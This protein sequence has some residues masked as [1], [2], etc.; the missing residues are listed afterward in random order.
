MPGA[1]AVRFSGCVCL[2][3]GVAC[4]FAG[5]VLG[6]LAIQQAT[7][8]SAYHHA[9]ACLAGAR[10]DADCLHA[11]DGSVAG[12]T[13]SPGSGRV[14]ADYALDVRT[15]STTLH[16]T[17]SSDSPML[18]DALDGDPAVLTMWRGV[19]VSVVTDGR[20]EVTTSVPDTALASDLGNSEL[21]GGVG[22]LFV[23]GAR[24]ARRNRRAGGAQPLTRP[25]LP[26]PLLPLGLCGIVVAVVGAAPARRRLRDAPDPPVSTA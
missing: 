13:E 26:P 4:L 16:L 24:A 18:A 20:S 21:T 8:I 12:V 17:F 11:V 19:P 2:V 1:S 6:I 14:S 5:G 22:V 25:A 23:L 15:A 7:E 3:L 10:S 9:R